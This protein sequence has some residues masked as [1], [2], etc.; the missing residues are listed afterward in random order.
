MTG[1]IT[2]S[3]SMSI[4]MDVILESNE[5]P[6]AYHELVVTVTAFF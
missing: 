4:Y 1:I 3:H 6:V 2:T 5:N